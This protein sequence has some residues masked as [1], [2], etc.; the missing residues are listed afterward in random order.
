MGSRSGGVGVLVM[1]AMRTDSS[2][3][4]GPGHPYNGLLQAA[5]CLLGLLVLGGAWGAPADD[6][7]A[8]R[9]TSAQY[10]GGRDD[11]SPSVITKDRFDALVTD[12]E[13]T[14]PGA[15]Q[16]NAKPG[17]SSLQSADHEFWFFLADVV[18]FGDDDNDG[19]FFGIDLLFDADTIFE[20]ADVYAVLYLSF[21]GGPWNEYHVT[22]VFT[23]F[24]A[25]SDDE[26]VVVTELE[27]GYPRGSYDLLIELYDTFDGRFVASFGPVDTS[28]LSFLPLEDFERDDPHFR[29]PVGHSHGGG[30]AVRLWGVAI[31]ALFTPAVFMRR[32]RPHCGRSHAG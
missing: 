18:L 7:E 10:E 4:T 15:R 28:E 21:E 27:S 29:P 6:G 25:T 20:A 16:G 32:R 19:H 24:G 12:G 30:G 26:Y 31:L 3:R 22:D 9:S 5:L 17:T 14:R 1:D 23:I 8:R 2:N 13:R 11:S